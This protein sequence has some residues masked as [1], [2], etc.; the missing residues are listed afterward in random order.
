MPGGTPANRI[1][2]GG[3][4]TRLGRTLALQLASMTYR[5]KAAA[6][7]GAAAGV[8]LGMSPPVGTHVYLALSAWPWAAL[9]QA[10]SR[11]WIG[12]RDHSGVMISFAPLVR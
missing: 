3:A 4:G 11:M 6:P 1:D 9:R 12:R 2:V 7:R 10:R 8:S 5:K